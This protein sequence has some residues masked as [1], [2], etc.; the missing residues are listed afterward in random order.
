[1][2]ASEN[3]SPLAILR[4]EGRGPASHPGLGVREVGL[5]RIGP[6][7]PAGIWT[8]PSGIGCCWAGLDGCRWARPDDWAG[9]LL[10]WAELLYRT[11][12]W[13]GPARTVLVAPG[14]S[15]TI[16]K[17]KETDSISVG[18]RLG[19]V[20][21]PGDARR[22]QVRRSR[23]LSFYDL[24]VESRQV[25]QGGLGRIGPNGPAEIWTGPSGIGCCWAGLDGCRWAEPNDW[26][27]PLLDWAEL[28]ESEL[29]E[30][31]GREEEERAGESSCGRSYG[32][33][34]GVGPWTVHGPVWSLGR[35]G[36]KRLRELWAKT[37]VRAEGSTRELGGWA[38][39]ELSGPGARPNT[40]LM[41]SNR[42]G[43]DMNPQFPYYFAPPT[44]AD[45][46]QS[47]SSSSSSSVPKW[48]IAAIVAVGVNAGILLFLYIRRREKKIK[49]KAAAEA[50]AKPGPAPKGNDG[51]PAN[52]PKPFPTSCQSCGHVGG[53]LTYLCPW[54][55]YKA[56]TSWP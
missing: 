31:R 9:P 10:D 43:N 40:F 48:V 24:K 4:P 53:T 41:A 7:G 55:K 2:D 33:G 20:H 1:M 5:G 49:K 44:W 45:P 15:C 38:V 37:N 21:F 52:P 22:T 6:N 28:L 16:L 42:N 25:T 26:A 18:T 29:R 39:G 47:S 50:A 17:K 32:F 51:K 27:G 36:R 11:D 12:C 8:G 56:E 54:C 3:E 19:S 14:V 35:A 34:W 23:H 13:T 46:Y 30:S